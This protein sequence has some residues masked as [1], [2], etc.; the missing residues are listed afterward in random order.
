MCSESLFRL[1]Q[2]GKVSPGQSLCI[3]VGQDRFGCYLTEFGR[4]A[5]CVVILTKFEGKET[6]G[7]G[8]QMNGAVI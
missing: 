4:V 6:V 2:I 3:K 8:S 5:K 7:G 1:G